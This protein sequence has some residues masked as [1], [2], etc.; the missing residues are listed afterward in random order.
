M[1]LLIAGKEQSADILSSSGTSMSKLTDPRD[2][3]SP[4][5]QSTDMYINTLVLVEYVQRL[6]HNQ[7]GLETEHGIRDGGGS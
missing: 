6:K 5:T 3:P 7:E 4:T 2:R 1:S